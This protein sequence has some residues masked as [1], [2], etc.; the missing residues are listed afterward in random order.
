VVDGAGRI[1]HRFVG[2]LQPREVDRILLPLLAEL[3][4]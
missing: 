3:A 2:P 1:R 4:S